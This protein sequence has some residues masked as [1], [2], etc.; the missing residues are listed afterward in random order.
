MKRNSLFTKI[1]ALM[2]CVMMVIG[3]LPMS[4]FAAWEGEILVEPTYK[5]LTIGDNELKVYTGMA[6]T[7]YSYT[8]DAEGTLSITMPNYIGWSYELKKGETVVAESSTTAEYP[9]GCP[10]VEVKAGDAIT[11]AVTTNGPTTPVTT[12]IVASFDYT[13]GTEN[14]P[15]EV[16]VVW[17]DNQTIEAGATKYFKVVS[18][19]NMVWSGTMNISSEAAYTAIV[20]GKTY[21]SVEG[22]V[23]APASLNNMLGSY[24]YFS[25][26]NSGTESADF[27]FSFAVPEG[28]ANNRAVLELGDHSIN[29][30]ADGYYA[31][32]N[33]TGEGTL[34][35]TM[36]SDNWQYLVNNVTSYIYGDAQSSKVEEDGSTGSASYS[37][38]V[39]AGDVVEIDLGTADATAGNVSFT[40]SFEASPVPYVAMIGEQGFLT[41]ADALN[42]A[43][44]GQTVTMIDNSE[45][46]DAYLI[47][48][49]GVTLDLASCELTAKAVIGLK[50]SFLTADPE[51]NTGKGGLLYVAKDN[52][53]LSSSAVTSK[54][55]ATHKIVPIYI[56]NHYMFGE[57]MIYKP[58]TGDFFAADTTSNNGTG[59]I[60]FRSNFLNPVR[61]NYLQNGCE[62]FGLSFIV[63]V[64]YKQHAGGD[65]YIDVEQNFYYPAAMRDGALKGTSQLN[66]TTINC[67]EYKD[68]FFT[69]SLVTDTGIVVSSNPYVWADYA[70]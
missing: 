7:I 2:L 12:N 32:Y 36:T 60:N 20:D 41:V 31:V 58:Q 38:A 61:K 18:M 59:T 27:Q 28:T 45:E 56:N 55:T 14:A 34:T 21:E 52:V 15:I 17:G 11:L 63:S 24:T 35:I 68:L 54:I 3:C 48:Q 49:P 4:A 30:S 10:Y 43:T 5:D 8:A 57:F 19:T 69:I 26:T 53:S 47:I 23:S 9:D 37:V 67:N 44:S 40:L 65:N 25:V 64:S 46:K 39:N 13:P 50:G 29:V 66:A 33:A 51:T 62:G 42:A 22:A 1:A 6:E 16:D 70:A